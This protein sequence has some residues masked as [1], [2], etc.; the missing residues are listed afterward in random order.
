MK[1]TIDNILNKSKISIVVVG[2][3]RLH[4]IARLLNSLLT[5]NYPNN[6]IPLVISIDCSNDK[7]LYDYII[8]FEWLFGDK[9]VFIQEKLLG[10]KDHIFKCGDLTR[11]FKA[12]ILFEDDIYVSPEFYNYAHA[13][14]EKYKDDKRISGI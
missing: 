4:S 2:Y 14:I 7:E 6:D 3:N 12:I 8:N 9:Y 13:A 5:A 10:L 11:Y 1:I